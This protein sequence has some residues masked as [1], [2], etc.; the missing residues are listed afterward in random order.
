MQVTSHHHRLPLLLL[1]ILVVALIG[2]TVFALDNLHRTGKIY[3]YVAAS[4]SASQPIVTRA[5]V[6]SETLIIPS[7]DMFKT[8][9]IWA[10]VSRDRPLAAEAGYSL[11]PIPVAH[12]DKNVPM[13]IAAVISSDLQRLVNAAE[14]DEE[15]LMISS[16]YRSLED[17]KDVYDSFVKKNGVEMAGIYVLPVGASEHHTGLSVDF[18]SVST[19]CEDDSDTCALSQSGAAWLAKN[20]SKYGFIQRY[21]QGKQ[22]ITGVGYEPWHYRYVGIPFATALSSSDLTFDEAIKQLAPGYARPR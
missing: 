5:E 10:L 2:V 17:Q 7:Y 15:P 12:G 8:G 13:K 14:A 22:Q 19:D 4:A 18:S 1:R 21:P 20:A 11:T 9:S 16:A 3:D 6:G